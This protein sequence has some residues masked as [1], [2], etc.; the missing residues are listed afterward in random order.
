MCCHVYV[1]GAYKRTFGPLEYGQPSYFYLIVG[2]LVLFF[3]QNVCRRCNKANAETLCI[4]P[5]CCAEA[6]MWIQ[7]P[8]C[9]YV[10]QGVDLGEEVPSHKGMKHTGRSRIS[11]RRQG[12]PRRLRFKNFVCQKE[13][14]WA[15]RGRALGTPP[16]SA[17][18]IQKG[19]AQV[20]IVK[21]F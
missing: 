1:I 11:P 17:N 4:S 18:E 19:L 12:L 5:G 16:R 14:I 7:L 6:E 13:R 15:L 3:L 2:F 10:P 8:C 9:L 21:H 20:N